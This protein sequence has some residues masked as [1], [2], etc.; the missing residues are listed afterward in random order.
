MSNVFLISD[1]HLGHKGI[2][3]FLNYD[4]TKVRPWDDVEKMNED[5]I[6]N[7]NKVVKPN[8]KVYNL[9][10][11]V[12]NRKFLPLN[13]RLNGKKRLI[14]GNHDIFPTKEY[15]E[16][17]F[18]EIYGVRVLDSIIL[19]HI[20]LAIDCITE[21]YGTNVH[22]HLH[23]NSLKNPRYFCVSVEQINYTPIALEDLKI[24]IKKRYEEYG[25]NFPIFSSAKG[26]S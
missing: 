2:C 3:Q 20:P 5:L 26:V 11:V 10:D 14:R 7:W 16:N 8:D 25:I 24:K 6:D 23:A 22:G 13:L 12:I 19:S 17:G 15:I 4:R 1:L 21:R 9:G 18:D